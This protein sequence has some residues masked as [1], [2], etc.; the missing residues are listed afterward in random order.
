[1]LDFS[2][3]RELGLHSEVSAGI[4]HALAS[5]GIAGI[6]VGA[7]ARDLHLHY[8][9]DIPVQRRTEDID[10]A[11]MV[12]A[13]SEFD[14]LR[15]RLIEAGACHVVDEN[16]HRLRHRSGIAIDLVPFGGLET[17]DRQI[18]WPPAGL[19]VMNVFGFTEALGT[20]EEV[21][22]PGGTRIQVVSLSALALLKI[23]AW[24]DRHIRS[25][26]KDA[27][28]LLLICRN[29][30]AIPA[31][32]ARLWGEF[33]GWADAPDFDYEHSGARMLGHDLRGLLDGSGLERIATILKAQLD[34]NEIGKLPQEMNRRSPGQARALLQSL[35]RGLIGEVTVGTAA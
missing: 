14:A 24:D 31:N 18:A 22:L 35:Y 1:M 11:F 9:A 33:A 23:V 13:W 17:G 7:F 28:D 16:K 25:P 10:I 3:R 20:A 15:G 4:T 30:L 34:E 29:Y 5:L 8:G 32:E 12:G 21:L 6:V 27:A 26:G 2:Q 19:A